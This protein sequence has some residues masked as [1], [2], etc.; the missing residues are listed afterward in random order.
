MVGIKLQTEKK[1]MIIAEKQ[2]EGYAVNFDVMY[3]AMGEDYDTIEEEIGKREGELIREYMPMLNTQI[4]DENNWRR[5]THR[6]IEFDI[7]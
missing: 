5:Y 7:D 2:R 1:Y 6:E 3:Y 4:P